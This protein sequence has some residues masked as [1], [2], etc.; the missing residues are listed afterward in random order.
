M[1]PKTI[2]CPNCG[3]VASADKDNLWRPFCSRRCKLIDLGEWIHEEHHI[4]GQHADP[5][6]GA[7]W[8]DGPPSQ[9]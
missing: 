8:Q 5:G 4:P 6:A 2:P 9:H 1:K 3:E 7:P